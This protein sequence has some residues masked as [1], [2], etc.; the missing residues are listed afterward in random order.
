M[1]KNDEFSGCPLLIYANK[2]DLLSDLFDPAKF[3]I[4]MGLDKIKN[5]RKW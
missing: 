2:Q 3:A 1:L 4:E 5:S